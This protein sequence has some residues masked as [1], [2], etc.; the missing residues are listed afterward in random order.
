MEFGGKEN[1]SLYTYELYELILFLFHN[2]HFSPTLF[3][4]AELSLYM[5]F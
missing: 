5:G 1:R 3:I 2:H 4:L